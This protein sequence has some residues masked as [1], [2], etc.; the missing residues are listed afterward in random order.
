MSSK[1]SPKIEIT[2]SKKAADSLLAY[3][4]R[5]GKSKVN[6]SSLIMSMLNDL[7]TNTD[8]TSKLQGDI[9]RAKMEAEKQESASADHIKALNEQIAKTNRVNS[10]LLELFIISVGGNPP[11]G[12]N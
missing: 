6:Y 12:E 11:G 1:D 5:T 9:R 7:A 10:L 2:I 4:T 3:K 8:I